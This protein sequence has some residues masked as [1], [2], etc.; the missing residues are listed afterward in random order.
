MDGINTALLLLI[1]L[2]MSSNSRRK[3]SKTKTRR[4]H[5][6]SDIS[7]THVKAMRSITKN[8]TGSGPRKSVGPKAEL[9]SE[10][11]RDASLTVPPFVHGNQDNKKRTSI[12]VV[13]LGWPLY[14]IQWATL[15]EMCGGNGLQKIVVH[16]P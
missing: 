10:N 2:L 13:Y 9:Q 1:L 3:P 7:M 5:A 16:K 15:V 6:A 12:S 11:S 8:G 14:G 4:F